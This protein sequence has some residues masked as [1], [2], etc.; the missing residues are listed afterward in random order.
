[1]T[2]KLISDIPDE[3]GVP[4]ENYLLNLVDEGDDV[5]NSL[6]LY[7]I[8]GFINKIWKEI[9]DKNRRIGVRKVCQGS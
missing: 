2:H 9:I 5:G 3:P 7:D 6:Y 8:G 4:L 1:M